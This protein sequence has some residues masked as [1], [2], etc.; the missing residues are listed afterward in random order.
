MKSK[1]QSLKEPLTKYLSTIASE[2]IHHPILFF[3]VSPYI[4]CFFSHFPEIKHCRKPVVE[5]LKVCLS[6]QGRQDLE[7]V[8]NAIDAAVDFMCYKGGERIA[9]I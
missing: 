5:A 7:I 4:A 1:P 2:S 6:D 8:D 9:S 3:D